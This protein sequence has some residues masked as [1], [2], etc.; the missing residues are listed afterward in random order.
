MR[1]GIV[2][3]LIFGLFSTSASASTLRLDVVGTASG[4]ISGG[5][6]I[7]SGGSMG[8]WSY[9]IAA[10]SHLPVASQH[11]AFL[12]ATTGTAT[13]ETDD[14]G[15]GWFSGCDGLLVHLCST[16]TAHLTAGADGSGFALS[17]FNGSRGFWGNES[18]LTV[19]ID[20]VPSFHVDGVF[21]LGAPGMALLHAEFTEVSVIAAPLPA[22][23]LLLLTGAG[24]LAASRRPA[25]RQG[26]DATA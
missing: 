12:T 15:R 16:G 10:L 2:S 19:G 3:A 17:G 20:W 4:Q 5:I 14:L 21:Y 23:A 9:D 26:A 8:P 18:R 24:A 13:Y 22:G 25:R 7:G 1:G 11:L 6:S